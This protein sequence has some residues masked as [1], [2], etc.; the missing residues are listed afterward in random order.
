MGIQIFTAY[1]MSSYQILAFYHFTPIEDP[2]AEVKR[3]K[4]FLKNLDARARLYISDK[5]V[6]AQMSLKQKMPRPIKTG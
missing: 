2:F 6:N 5:G 1:F 3:Q 4:N